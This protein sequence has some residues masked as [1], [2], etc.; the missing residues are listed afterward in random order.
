MYQRLAGA[1]IGLVLALG[2]TAA[3]AQHWPAYGEYGYGAGFDYTRNPYSYPRSV[4]AV[5]PSVPDDQLALYGGYMPNAYYTGYAYSASRAVPFY[6]GQAFCQ[7]AGSYLYCADIESGGAFL[8]S[9]RS[10]TPMQGRTMFGVIPDRNDSAAVYSGVVSSRTVDGTTTFQGLLRSNTGSEAG[11]DCAGPLR[12]EF[13]AL[14]C[15]P[16][17]PGLSR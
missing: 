5:G 6:S 17:Q 16:V 9:M 10:G 4:A 12:G 14:N 7:S 15:R 13:V 3:Y 11:V 1:L 8:L 2:G